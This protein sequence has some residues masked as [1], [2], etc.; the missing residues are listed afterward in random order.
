MK[1]DSER[2]LVSV[3]VITYNHERSIAR[4]IESVLAQEVD[5][6]YEIIIAEDCSTD[7][8]REIV[9]EYAERY[10]E[11]IKLLLQEHNVGMKGNSDALRRACR[12]I[13]RSHIEGDDVWCDRGKLKRQIE[14]LEN[15]PDYIAIGGAFDCYD[16]NWKRTPFPWGNLS[17]VYALEDTYTLEHARRWLMPAHASS[18]TYRNVF[19]DLDERMMDIYES[20]KLLGDR[21]LATFLVCQ[22]KIK[23]EDKLVMHRGVLRKAQNSYTA[24]WRKIPNQS[25]IAYQWFCETEDMVRAWFGFELDLSKR[26]L[27]S[28]ENALKAYG[29]LPTKVNWKVIREI[30]KMS[31]HK[32][33]Y[34]RYA[35]NLVKGK[36][37]EKR[38]QE[39]TKELIKSLFRYP[40]K[41]LKK[42]REVNSKITVRNDKIGKRF[43]QE[44]L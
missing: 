44:N 17:D 11:I 10:P 33:E 5:F 8:T 26:K 24:N 19:F 2:P 6:E 42:A 18:L 37:K 21:K 27:V 39:G 15:N 29:K 35:C 3:S 28:W 14:F 23:Y 9:K 30:L 34:I 43:L 36:I 40:V 31:Q 41:A 20:A 25:G 1:N 13:Y 7:R 22:G 16:E 38:Q 4:A 12:G 32:G